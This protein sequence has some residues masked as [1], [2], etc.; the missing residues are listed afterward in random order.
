MNRAITI[1][2]DARM[3]RLTVGLLASAAIVLIALYVALRSTFSQ[4]EADLQKALGFNRVI[5]DVVMVPHRSAGTLYWRC[6]RFRAY[7]PGG[8]HI[9]VA[10]YDY[11]LHNWIVTEELD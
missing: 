1:F 7:Y 10:C 11:S 4:I 8:F 9:K 6:A 3:N 5:V 2:Y